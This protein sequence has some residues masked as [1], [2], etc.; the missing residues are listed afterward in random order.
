MSAGDAAA[1]VLV[2]GHESD[3]GVDL[4]RF[5][6]A[7]GATAV[8][9][10]RALADAVGPALDGGGPVVVVPMTF[11]RDPSMV[12]EAARTLRWL[13]PRRPGHLALAAP[14][15]ITD[16]LVAHLRAATRRALERDPGTA[17][18]LVARASNP[19]D[20]AELRRV[21]HLVAVHGAG[22]EVAVAT[23]EHDAD[24][25]EAVRRLRLLGA[26]RTTLVPAGFADALDVDV[27]AWSATTFSGPLVGDAAVARI[28]AER[29]ATARHDLGHGRDGIDAGLL[30]DHD[31]GYAHT[32][33]D[34]HH[35][36]AVPAG[37]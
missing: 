36:H 35:A 15:G 29:V 14:F 1:V 9:S 4:V 26:E 28:V 3:H 21:A 20:D 13:A 10:G 32:H 8:G 7:L 31:H 34:H 12:A 5:E 2:G 33:A 18:V 19:F 27:T 22:A 24:V 11:G 25:A 16:H 30:A 6:Q 23:V 37:R 17:V